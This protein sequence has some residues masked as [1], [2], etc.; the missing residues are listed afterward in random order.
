[1]AS[2]PSTSNDETLPSGTM[3]ALIHT[4][5]GLPLSVLH[6]SSNVP[7]PKITNPTD[8]LIK[9]SHASLDPGA[10]IL[11]NFIPMTFRTKPSIP[12]TDFSGTVIATGKGVSASRELIPG[13]KVCGSAPLAAM[14]LH[15]RGVIAEYVVVPAENV[16]LK[17]EALGWEEAAGLPVAGMVGLSVM[18]LGRVK[19]GERVLVNGASGG[20]G[21][22]VVQM[23]K[24]AVGEEGRV[25]GICSARNE[26]MVKGLGADEVID[27]R[28]HA[29]VWKYL[30]QRFEAEPFDVILDCRGV[31]ELF[32]HCP[33]Y[34]KEGKPFVS[35][36]PARLDYSFLGVLYIVGYM[37][38]NVLWPR[39][40]GGVNR[41]Y[42]S[43]RAFASLVRLERVRRLAEDGLKVPIDSVWDLEDVLKAYE[44]A[45]SRHARGKVIVK[46]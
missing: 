43:A 3:K 41:P 26:G 24:K 7:I 21:S 22:V 32:V 29:P 36:G 15:G 35:V 10:S 33:R 34:L 25:V 45:E 42:L 5:R 16:V 18:D 23:A 38:S 31:Q 28:E 37:I 1:M 19:K 39:W 13:A 8:V 17:P 46:M 9:V 11:I 12:E 27:Y 30:E 4:S 14:I 2:F 20:I 6:L 44:V 40:L